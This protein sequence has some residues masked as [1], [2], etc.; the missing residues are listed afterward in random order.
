MNA[1]L[2]APARS[3]MLAQRAGTTRS[4]TTHCFFWGMPAREEGC[5]LE[6]ILP[7]DDWPKELA[8][9]WLRL[10]DLP[11]TQP[12]PSSSDLHDFFAAPS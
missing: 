12:E 11:A 8:Q 5:A 1:T 3:C 10:L 2:E 7:A 6:R 4:C 9:R